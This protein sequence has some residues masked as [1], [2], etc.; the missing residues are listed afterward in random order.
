M[1]GIS[2]RMNENTQGGAMGVSVKAASR[3]A[4]LTLSASDAYRL[5]FTVE[6]PTMVKEVNRNVYSIFISNIASSQSVRIH[7]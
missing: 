1:S 6:M 5:S 7:R 4:A 2:K 3:R